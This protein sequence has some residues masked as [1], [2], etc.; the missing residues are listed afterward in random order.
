MLGRLELL[1][2][3][4]YKKTSKESSRT[5]FDE[6]EDKFLD[7]QIAQRIFKEDQQDQIN[8]FRTKVEAFVF[9][10]ENQLIQISNYKKILDTNT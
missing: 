6:L 1:E 10:I 5:K 7:V 2:M 8:N 9:E 4:V 3:T